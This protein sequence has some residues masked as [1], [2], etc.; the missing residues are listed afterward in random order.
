MTEQAEALMQRAAAL[1][2]QGRQREAIAMFRQVLAILPEASEGWYELGYLLKAEGQYQEALDAYGQALARRVRRPEE[3]HLNRAVIYSDHLRRDAEA[4]QEL[5]AALALAPDYVPA[6]MNLGNLHEER[7]ERRDALSCYDRV[8]A[9]AGKPDQ[10]HPDLCLEALARTA[11]LRP[12]QTL[13]DPLLARLRGAT[14]A[15]SSKMVRANLL[16]ALGQ[17]YDRLQAFDLAFDAYAKANRW[18]LR[19]S[20]RTYDRAQAVRQAWAKPVLQWS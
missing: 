9:G 3:V 20:G 5:T 16:F 2:R 15:P 19:E 10:A 17:A 1:H 14:G 7:G 13:D 12:P 4:Q 18:L 11:K 6:L 8:L